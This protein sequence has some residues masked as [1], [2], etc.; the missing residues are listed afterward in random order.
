MTSELLEDLTRV[1]CD[2]VAIE[3][4]SDRLD[5]VGAAIDYAEAYAHASPGARVQRI[6][7]NNVPNLVVTLR[8]TQTPAL[9]LNAHLDVVPGRPGQFRPEVREGR[10][11]GRGAQDMKGAAA[12]LLRL[13][14]DL[15]ALPEPPDV[16]F[17]FVGDEEIGGFNGTGYLLEQGWRCQFFIAAEPTDLQVCFA[18]KG[19]MWVDVVIPGRPAHGSRPWDG[20]NPV[21]ALRDG[22]LVL[23]QHFPTP[24]EPAWVTTV[25]PTILAGGSA[26]NRIAEAVTLTLD[27]RH[28]PEDQPEAVLAAVRDAFPTSQVDFMRPAGPPLDTAPDDASVVRLRSVIGDVT[29]QPGQLYRE[30]YASDAR[31][32]SDVGIPAVCFGPVGAGLHSDE[33]WVEITSLGTTYAV[34]RRLAGG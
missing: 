3:S 16:G 14:R 32:Y 17:Q 29:G 26:S 5:L 21:A 19:S 9:L 20:R 33:E 13:M 30:H 11:Y 18:Q 31:F 4:T 23:E 24:D 28:V 12:V 8:D 22:L 6:T 2:L 34:L 25:V 1:T 10:I 7:A 27:I 15:A